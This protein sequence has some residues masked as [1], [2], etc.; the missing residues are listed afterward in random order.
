MLLD[1]FESDGVD[2]LFASPIAVMAPI[3]EELARRGDLLKL[4]YFRCRHELLAV[5]A[6]SGYYQATGRSQVAFLPTN[7]G[8]QNASMALR[9]AMHEHVPIVAISVDS[10]TWGE[11]PRTDPGVEWPSLLGHAAGPARSG[12]A[13]VKWAKQARTPSDVAH[14]WRRALYVANS[15]PRGPTLLEIPIELLMGDAAP[16]TFPRLPKANL[17][18]PPEEIEALADLL[19]G[20]KNPIIRTGYAGRSPAARKALVAIAEKL[21]APVFEFF[22]PNH[23]NFPRSHPLHGVGDMEAIL[24]ESDLIFVAG[25]DA[26]WHPPI[27]AL[28]SGCAVVHMAEDPL[29]PR[30]PYW[31][32]ATTHTLAGDVERNLEALARAL[33]SRPDPPPDRARRWEQ[34]F[35]EGRREMD[36]VADRL[37]RAAEDVVPAADLFRALHAAL[38]HDAIAVDEIVCQATSFLHH[39]FESKPIEQ[40]RGWHGALGTSL[41]VALGVRLARP[42]QTVVCVIGDGAWHYNPVPA[43]L[44]FAQ[45]YGMPLLIVICNNGQYA[46]QTANLRKFYPEG[47]AVSGQDFI[48]NVIRP[49]PDYYKAADGYGGAGE[50]VSQS[51][52]LAAAIERGLAAVAGGRTFILDVIVEP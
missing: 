45:E 47:S 12:E 36:A 42:G 38:P 23:H 13:V 14:E 2:C 19:A 48:G 17:V 43:A 25:A 32:Y 5:A 52:N 8:V 46:S 39:L 27:Q 30:A 37:A 51:A 29:R 6:A 41:G 15:I 20:A 1:Q 4:R 26:P 9:T 11:D 40:V 31:G 44:G 24:G 18:A 35:A 34:R 3:W 10:L 16:I 21:G 7:L 50:R 28:R 22:M 33:R 49:M